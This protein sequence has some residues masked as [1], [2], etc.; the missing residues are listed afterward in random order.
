MASQHLSQAWKVCTSATT[1][2]QVKGG[3]YCSDSL[4]FVVREG[5]GG[6]L[7]AWAVHQLRHDFIKHAD[8]HLRVMDN[9]NP[10][11]SDIESAVSETH[12]ALEG[13]LQRLRLLEERLNDERELRRPFSLSIGAILQTLMPARFSEC[14][15]ELLR[16]RYLLFDVQTPKGGVSLK[17]SI[18]DRLCKQLADL[19][20]GRAV[21]EAITWVVFGKVDSMLEEHE[22]LATDKCVLPSFVRKI[23]HAIMP[24][25]FTVAVSSGKGSA[26]TVNCE[27]PTDVDAKREMLD[28][29]R[30][31]LLFHLHESVAAL[32]TTQVLDIIRLFPSSAPAVEDLKN[33]LMQT[34]YRPRFIE[35][36]RRE[37][38]DKLL[39]AGTVTSEIL[40]QYVNLIKTL[41][42]LDPTGVVL[43]RVS[44]PIRSYLRY[45]P[46]TI[47]CI[48]NGM[49]VDGDLYAEL[50]RI[51]TRR[52]KDAGDENTPEQATELGYRG[53]VDED[54]ISID[55]D[56]DVNGIVDVEAYEN[57]E[58]EPVDAPSKESGF[59]PGGDAIATLI[60]IYGSSNLLVK[61]YRALLADRLIHNLDFD[62]LKEQQVLNLLIERF[63]G[64]AMHECS[65]MLQDVTNSRDILVRMKHET[66]NE[67]ND[68]FET[69]VISKEFWPNVDGEK[70]FAAPSEFAH[71][72]ERFSSTF[73][74]AK[75]PRK[76][77]W[78][79]GLGVV[80]LNLSFDDGR[81]KEVTVSPLQAAILLQF[82][83][84]RRWT[85]SA[86]QNTLEIE[87]QSVL[88]KA[89]NALMSKGLLR[90]TDASAREFETVEKAAD[91]EGSAEDDG[92]GGGGAGGEIDAEGEEDDSQ[93][94]V[95]E[96][97]ILAMLQ[98]LKESP[99]EKVHSMLKLF[100][101][102][103]VYDKTQ[104]QLAAFLARMVSEDKIEVQ[105]G[106]F[107]IKANNP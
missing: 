24:W 4:D 39:N 96:S 3:E 106:L 98:N 79:H 94:K 49:T 30:K 32:R 93:M 26:V 65:I 75:N 72:M 103:P 100:V 69:T 29:W 53:E 46:D 31:Q 12:Q 101:R 97:Y 57:W 70:K 18:E 63:G 42:I 1:G 67:N 90:A 107:K 81:A 37:F 48:V 71:H 92:A 80:S 68:T 47:R 86:L 88:S 56:Y 9:A 38:D 91:A 41:R 25:L 21:Q 85:L 11:H 95:F 104:D 45:R 73:E 64:E 16:A 105:A 17:H 36:L 99:L 54:L 43:E 27:E 77:V 14:L 23:E 13:S 5:L 52:R 74:K 102:T 2:V 51:P 66:E 87:E 76:L 60:T 84:Q 83:H 82:G 61:E 22:S 10:T 89:L 28:R 62:M 6:R 40:L 50:R 7:G 78:Q 44:E 35:L 20:F 34:D 8:T 33:C 19:G 59:R 55:G 15:Y 58:P